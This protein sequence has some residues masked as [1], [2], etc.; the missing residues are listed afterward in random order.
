MASANDF[1]MYAST[2]RLPCDRCG[3][4]TEH[5]CLMSF[6]TEVKKGVVKVAGAN[7]LAF[8]VTASD[9]YFE[10]RCVRCDRVERHGDNVGPEFDPV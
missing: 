1:N 2:R 5:E 6:R 9:R 7:Q 4:V 8:T 3:T 10:S